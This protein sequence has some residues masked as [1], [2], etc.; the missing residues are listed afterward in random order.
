MFSSIIPKVLNAKLIYT[1]AL[2]YL[3]TKDKHKIFGKGF[4][5]SADDY[6]YV[7]YAHK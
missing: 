4:S 2:L 1:C 3:V 7:H 6:T 5:T